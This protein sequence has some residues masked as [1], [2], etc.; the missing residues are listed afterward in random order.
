[1]HQALSL[2]PN[3]NPG[4]RG[5]VIVCGRWVDSRARDRGP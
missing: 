2:T 1:M 5:V 4:V 3:Q